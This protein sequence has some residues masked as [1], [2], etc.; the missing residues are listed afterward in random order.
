MIESLYQ[1]YI[2]RCPLYLTYMTFR[3][4]A[5]LPTSGDWLSL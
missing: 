4:L 3:T 1:Y 5:L 2:G